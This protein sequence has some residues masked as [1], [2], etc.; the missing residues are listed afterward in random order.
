[1]RKPFTF[2]TSLRLETEFP[3]ARI[4]HR[5]GSRT[6]LATPWFTKEFLSG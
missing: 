1:M 5:L 3:Y 6:I 2:L 4:L